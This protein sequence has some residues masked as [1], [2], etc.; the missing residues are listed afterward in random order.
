MS[1]FAE[2]RAKQRA[3]KDQ[4]KTIVNIG[5]GLIAFVVVISVYSTMVKD[6]K[7]DSFFDPDIDVITTESGLEY[8]DQVLGDGAMAGP[9]SIVAVH[10]TG[11]LT[12]G[13]KFDSSVDRGIPFEFQLGAGNVIQG[14]DE[15]VVGMKEGGKRLL[16]IPYQLGYGERGVGDAI[17]PMATLIF[18]VE[19]LTV[20]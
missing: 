4:N 8:Q 16:I 10:Y 19:L 14:W 18:E 20:R 3:A 6:G 11:W 9:G 17:P 1:K 12:D 7:K 15:G 5:L 13:S 2:K